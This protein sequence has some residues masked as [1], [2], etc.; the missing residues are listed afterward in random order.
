M[1]RLHSVAVNSASVFRTTVRVL[2]VLGGRVE[3]A[4][5]RGYFQARV[6]RRRRRHC[7]PGPVENRRFL[8]SGAAIAKLFFFQRPR[9]CVVRRGSVIGGRERRP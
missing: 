1:S 7:G 5:L 3:G 8:L 2:R 4:D 9:L 6:R